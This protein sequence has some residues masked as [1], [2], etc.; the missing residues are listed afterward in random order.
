MKLFS[1]FP[2]LPREYGLISPCWLANQ[3]VRIH[4]IIYY[5]NFECCSYFFLF[6]YYIILRKPMGSKWKKPVHSNILYIPLFFSVHQVCQLLATGFL[7]VLRAYD[8]GYDDPLVIFMFWR[9]IKGLLH[10][11]WWNI[12]SC[13][14]LI[15]NYIF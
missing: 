8:H 14:I 1:I 11:Y 7:L 13:R 10:E 6:V 2:S 5:T 15:V 12:V 4:W 9:T 3:I